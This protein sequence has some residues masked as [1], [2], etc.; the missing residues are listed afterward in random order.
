M[1][2]LRGNLSF[3]FEV[4][5]NEDEDDVYFT[6]SAKREPFRL[7]QKMEAMGLL[8]DMPSY[9]KFLKGGASEEEE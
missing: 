3:P 8:G 9:G 1:E 5:R 4:K 7:G 6:D 2:W